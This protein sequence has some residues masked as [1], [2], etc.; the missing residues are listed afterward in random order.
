ML[1]IER[2]QLSAALYAA[3]DIWQQAVNNGDMNS[4]PWK[5]FHSQDTNTKNAILHL[6]KTTFHGK[7]AYC[8]TQ[9]ADEIEHFLA[10]ISS[11]TK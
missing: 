11:S 3:L 7:C 1:R 10:K 5:Q 2:P 4:D 9:D 8:E 6:L